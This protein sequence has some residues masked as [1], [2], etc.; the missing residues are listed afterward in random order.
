[1]K[2]AARDKYIQ[3]GESKISESIGVLACS[4]SRGPTIVLLWVLMR[5]PVILV[6][7]LPFA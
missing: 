1:M 5:E 3:L 4:Y 6:I 2:P 7:N